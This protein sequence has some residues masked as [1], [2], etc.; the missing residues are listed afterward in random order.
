MVLVQM[1]E[2]RTRPEKQGVE[3]SACSTT[4][5]E[6]VELQREDVG[7]QSDVTADVINRSIAYGK[8]VAAAVYTYSK[9]DGA[10]WTILGNNLPFTIITDLKYHDP[11]QTLYAGTFG[12]AMHSYDISDLLGVDENQ[13]DLNAIVIYP[14]PATSEFI[15][16]HN[17]TSEGNIQLYDVSG[18]KIKEVFNGNFG[19]SKNITVNTDGIS[20]GLYFVKLTSGNQSVTKKLIVNN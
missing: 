7:I 2:M 1:P 10:S 8:S 13:I 11:T 20:S 4:F 16:S 6:Q 15:I 9:N 17:L 12:R 14:N 3:I 5:F 19:S 18:K